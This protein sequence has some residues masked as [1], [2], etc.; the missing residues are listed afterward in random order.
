MGFRAVVL[1]LFVSTSCLKPS[2][3]SCPTVDCPSNMV[4]DGIGGCALQEQLTD[5][6][7]KADGDVC[8][9]PGVDDGACTG[10]LCLPVGCGNSILTPN[11][12]CDDGNTNNGDGCSADCK[13]D[14]TCG[15]SIP[16]PAMG[17]QCDDGNAVQ[18][19]GC[20]TDCQFARC[21]DGIIDT[22]LNEACDDAELNSNNPNGCRPN[23]Q[24]PR[25]G[26][27]ILDN[28]E[29]CDDGN[30][31]N[32]DNCS[33]DCTSDE[34]CGNGIVDSF[35]GEVCDDGGTG[36]GD[37]C[38]A[39][40]K[41]TEACGNHKID[42]LVGEVCDDGNTINGDGCSSDCKSTE[43]CGNG[44]IDTFREQC[45]E[46]VDNSDDPNSTCRADCQLPKCGD[47][48]IDDELG[49]ECDDGLIDDP[50]ATPDGQFNSNTPNA[51]CRKN[52]QFQRCGDGIQDPDFGEVCDDGNST[53]GDDCSAD[54]KSLEIC[55]NAIIDAVNQEQCDEGAGNANTPDA[56]CRVSCELPRCGDG[57]RDAGQGE[58]CDDPAGNSNLANAACRTNCQPQ[59]CGD[60]VEDLA[61][62]EVCDDANA[63]AGDGCSADCK[64]KEICG[65][66]IVDVVKNEQC[67]AGGA[68]NN[69]NPNAA[70]RV[71]CVL[72]RCGD[73]VRDNLTLGEACDLGGANSNTAN[74][75]CRTNCQPQR[76]GDGIRDTAFGEVCDDG[77]VISGDGCSADCRSL[78]ICRNGIVDFAKGEQCDDNNAINLDQCHNDCTLPRCGDGIVDFNEQCDAGEANNKNTP[79][80]LCRT[81]CTLPRCGDNIVDNGALGEVCDDGN[82]VTGDTCRPDCKSN[83]TCGNQIVDL[84]MNEQCDDGNG[85]N[86]DGCGACKA[87]DLITLTPGQTPPPRRLHM[88]AYDGA[89]QRLVMFGGLSS[90]NAVLADTWEWDGVSWTQMRPKKSPQARHGAAMAYDQKR[91]RVILFGGFTQNANKQDTWEWNGSDWVER[92]PANVPPNFGHHGAMAYDPVRGTL[93]LTYCLTFEWT[94]D[95]WTQ[96]NPAGGNPCQN[97]STLASDAAR[98]Q[99]V[100]SAGSRTFVWTGAGGGT[101]SDKGT[102]AS[103][104]TGFRQPIV[105]DASIGKVVLSGGTANVTW[106]WNGTAWAQVNVAGS[107]SVRQHTA[108]AYDAVRRQVVLFGGLLNLN[109]S[110]LGDTMLRR[111]STWSPALPFTQPQPRMGASVAYDP[112]RKRVVM[113]G[114]DQSCIPCG[115]HTDET[116]EWD[117]RQFSAVDG[118]RPIPQSGTAMVYNAASRSV[119]M[120]ATSFDFAQS[121]G[122]TDGFGTLDRLF[123]FDGTNWSEV[124]APDHPIVRNTS[125]VYDP[126]ND[127][128]M[129]FGGRD[130]STFQTM[131]T[132]RGWGPGTGWFDIDG[133][134]GPVSRLSGAMTAYDPIRQRTVLFGGKD[135]N[136]SSLDD[137][138]EWDGGS[139]NESGARG[140]SAR[141]GHTVFYNPDARQI[142]VYGNATNASNTEDLWDWNGQVWTQRSIDA[143]STVLPH[144]KQS[145][146]YD[147]AR[148]QIFTFGGRDLNFQISTQLNLL[149]Y[150]AAETV[151]ACTS[152]TLDY[153]R[154]GKAGCADDE[155]WS[156]CTPLCPPGSPADCAAGTPRCGDGQCGAFEDCSICPS[157]CGVCAGTCGDFSCNVGETAANCPNDC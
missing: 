34:T 119:M 63:V 153:D 135:E 42:F 154:D 29:I 137:I 9:Y 95:D 125:L 88:M 46:G 133:G 147:S 94:G 10:G 117:G 85:R 157:D 22:T 98:N 93:I 43:G 99:I 57:I 33:A 114:G 64:S 145:V 106:E 82:L 24:L 61:K 152:A 40:C 127:V 20:H 74:A 100:M 111:A 107:P 39:D 11:E 97:G 124:P 142:S 144:Y 78:E 38:S 49:E 143:G 54:C 56:P 128:V 59:R 84:E 108:A 80:A 19:D 27:D 16:D 90:Q 91:K 44:I 15:N 60:G 155:C 138:W 148:H 41:S 103:F 140:P 30:V 68:N 113:F 102:T 4:C 26:D 13:S 55:G 112:L 1:A 87:E 37:G 32:G 136:R 105:F 120:L 96:L 83:L 66:G 62:G 72:P 115:G 35:K 25:C 8:R 31:V 146:A 104:P 156:V 21:G 116:W 71:G 134:S 23:C 18:D 76:C 122:N 47:E 139:W 130:E 67:D 69:N 17:E 92:T 109:G 123:T 53:S 118:A 7:G 151:E 101:W 126:T 129:T 110:I 52:C 6:E 65:N 50:D 70:C 89:R 149:Q 48:V 132:L 79:N 77:N 58:G 131:Q 75:T 36:D 51:R 121:T 5:C 2:L 141:F 3:T 14:E 12:V 81:N 73:G 28:G 150:R 86:R 45:D